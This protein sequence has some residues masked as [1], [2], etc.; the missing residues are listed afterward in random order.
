[1][2]PSICHIWY[3]TTLRLV[4]SEGNRHF[5]GDMSLVYPRLNIDTR[6][7]YGKSPSIPQYRIIITAFTTMEVLPI[8]VNL[9]IASV[10]WHCEIYRNYL[11]E[12]FIIA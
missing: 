9:G 8:N 3:Y 5:S 6:V 12:N 2:V 7:P 11:S 1:M 10:V 4:N